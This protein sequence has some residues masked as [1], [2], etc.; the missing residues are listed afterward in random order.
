MII[1][2]AEVWSLLVE[3]SQSSSIP[4]VEDVGD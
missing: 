4:Q 3:A 2:I 1:N